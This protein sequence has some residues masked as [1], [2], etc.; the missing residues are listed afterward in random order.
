MVP[1]KTE[2]FFSPFYHVVKNGRYLPGTDNGNVNCTI[3][4]F[5]HHK[6]TNLKAH[7]WRDTPLPPMNKLTAPLLNG[8]HVIRL[9]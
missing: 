9:P 8:S 6:R 4:R 5:S 1:V 7:L 2:L 3:F